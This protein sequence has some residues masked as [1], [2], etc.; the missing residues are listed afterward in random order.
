MRII[1]GAIAAITSFVFFNSIAYA[2]IKTDIKKMQAEILAVQKAYEIR[3]KALERKLQGIQK[4]Q[5]NIK[6]K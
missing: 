1:T 5:S 6:K 2:T 4:N 3:I